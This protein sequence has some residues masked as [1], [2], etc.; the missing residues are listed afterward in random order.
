MQRSAEIASGLVIAS[1]PM[2]PR[3]FGQWNLKLKVYYSSIRTAQGRNLSKTSIFGREVTNDRSPAHKVG[4]STKR[5]YLELNDL[6]HRQRFAKE[7]ASHSKR[8]D[9]VTEHSLQEVVGSGPEAHDASW[10]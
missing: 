2:M 10:V 5:N 9:N 6:E 3:L 4:Q 1:M 7:P 8:I